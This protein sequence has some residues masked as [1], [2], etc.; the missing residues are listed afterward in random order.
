[1]AKRIKR[2]EKS[3]N[4]L[5][6]KPKGKE[7]LNIPILK[8]EDLH[9]TKNKVEEEAV[10]E[11]P[12][13]EIIPEAKEKKETPN[14][15]TEIKVEVEEVKEE[16]EEKEAIK[17][18]EKEDKEVSKPFFE[19]NPIDF[20]DF[21][22]NYSDMDW[23]ENANPLEFITP[24]ENAS[25]RFKPER[26]IK[27]SESLEQLK[28]IKVGGKKVNQKMILLIKWWEHKDV[29]ASIRNMLCK[30]AE[31]QGYDLQTY[32]NFVLGEQLNI[33]S[34]AY[35]AIGRLCFIRNYF[36]SGLSPDLSTYIHKGIGDEV[37]AINKGLYEKIVKD[38]EGKPREELITK[39]KEYGIKED[40]EVL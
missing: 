38:C 40:I 36:L 9:K 32:F 12:K 39:I 20:E 17:N 11:T 26:E 1:M 14:T 5:N 3:F 10:K 28:K 24:N 25:S 34:G 2:A 6:F 16:K 33:L 4:K 35:N 15:H 18:P 8:I 23:L 13:D 30:E 19:E 7:H 21:E 22:I 31:Q 37:W 29:R 27:V